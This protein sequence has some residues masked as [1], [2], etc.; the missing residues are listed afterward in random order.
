ML[1]RSDLYGS[2]GP[3]GLA[4][5]RARDWVVD[6][7]PLT[8]ELKGTS[9]AFLV[10]AAS[11][12][13]GTRRLHLSGTRGMQ[14]QVSLVALPQ[15]R[16]EVEVEASWSH[17]MSVKQSAASVVAGIT[18]GDVIRTVVHVGRGE[19][20][21]IEQIAAE[22]NLGED[23]IPLRVGGDDLKAI[24]ITASHAAASHV[25]ATERTAQNQSNVRVFDLP[26]ESF[27]SATCPVIVK[28]VAVDAHGR[29]TAG[30]A[31]LRE[32]S[33]QQVAGI[34]ATRR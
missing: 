12:K 5:P 18:P 1:F 24:E 22:Q 23:R 4:G 11:P 15:N 21:T 32:R 33:P 30:W 31:T 34:S 13:G 26:A 20:L 29:R 7:G 28:V 6:S 19:D 10:A 2:V 16:P 14:L 17:R 25:A 3:W 27:S 9:A 8:L